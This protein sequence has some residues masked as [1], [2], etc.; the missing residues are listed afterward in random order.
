L[1]YVYHLRSLSN[2]NQTYTGYASDLK[3]RLNDHNTG[4]S[5]HTAKYMPWE[6]ICYHAFKDKRS[7]QEFEYYL[8]TGS[9]KVFAKKRFC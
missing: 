1:F 8:K 2:P 6:L 4:L 5:K 3:K 9:G 7:A